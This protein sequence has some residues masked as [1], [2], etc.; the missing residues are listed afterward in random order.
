MTNGNIEDYIV[1][2]DNIVSDELCDRILNEYSNSVEWNT[3]TIGTQNI[4]DAT[5]RSASVITISHPLVMENNTEIRKKIDSDMFLCASTSIQKYNEMFPESSIGED[6]GYD[7]LRYL[8]GQFYVQHTDN[9]KSHAR[10]VS[11][12]FALNDDYEGGEFAFWNRD[13]IYNLKKGSA[14]LFP[15]NF[16]YPHEIMPVLRGTRYSIVTWF[17]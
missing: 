16:V 6:T 17:I 10:T 9:F 13:K 7:L 1:V 15:S 14:I 3:T 11:C 2:F 4:V 12:S 5:K 8:E